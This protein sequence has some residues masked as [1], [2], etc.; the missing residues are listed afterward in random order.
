MYILFKA[1]HPYVVGEGLNSAIKVQ[2]DVTDVV[3]NFYEKK[4]LEGFK[5]K[6]G[7]NSVVYN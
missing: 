6:M 4:Y 1:R 3:A 7:Q 5:Q 2:G